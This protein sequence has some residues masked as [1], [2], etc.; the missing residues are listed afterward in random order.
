MASRSFHV[1][2]MQ[3]PLCARCTGLLIGEVILAPLYIILL[4][5]IWWVSLLLILPLA[6]DGIGQ[7]LGFWLSDNIRRLLTGL[8]GG[9]GL[10]ALAFQGLMAL[11]ERTF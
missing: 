1:R 8:L 7:Y 2:G 5:Q 10:I 11:I 3:C 9:I 6:V 4:P